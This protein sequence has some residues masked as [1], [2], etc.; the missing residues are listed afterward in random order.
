MITNQKEI[1][2]YYEMLVEKIQIMKVFSLLG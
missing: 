1:D 2:T